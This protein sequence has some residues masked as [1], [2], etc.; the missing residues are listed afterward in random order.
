MFWIETD[1][2]SFQREGGKTEIKLVVEDPRP[3]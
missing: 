1:I 3:Q 2:Y